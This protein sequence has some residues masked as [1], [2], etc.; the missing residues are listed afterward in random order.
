MTTTTKTPTLT[1]IDAL[2]VEFR[3]LAAKPRYDEAQV[4][5]LMS[6]SP[7]GL[8]LAAEQAAYRARDEAYDALDAARR[9]GGAER[10][11]LAKAAVTAAVRA[12]EAAHHAQRASAAALE[13]RMACEPPR[14]P[15][16][17]TDL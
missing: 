11:A 5:R 8:M 14:V 3:R 6:V 9:E 7:Y 13:A 4:L 15:P 17:M 2:A 10:V 12:Y 1:E 16:E